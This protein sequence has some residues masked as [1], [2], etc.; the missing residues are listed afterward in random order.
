M[1]EQAQALPFP[2]APPI[3]TIQHIPWKRAFDIG[4]SLLVLTLGTPLFLLLSLF[5]AI[6]SKGPIFYKH[7]RIGRGGRSFNCYKFRTMHQGADQKLEE[8][9]NKH[10]ELHQ[11]WKANFKL[12]KD[13]RITKIG[14][15]L[16]KT[17]L[18]ELPQFFNVLKGELSIVGPRPIIQEELETHFADVAT[19]IL[20][21]RPGITGLWQVSGRS[22][23]SYRRRIL[24]D[25]TYLKRKS[26]WLD[27]WLILKTIP[28]V[29]FA[30]G[31]C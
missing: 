13:P 5:I 12:K 16:R 27:F 2:D 7:K 29:L 30:K 17:S 18:D 6:S 25:L 10:P 11:E 31:A 24:L 8:L 15:F 1:M 28:V 9:L 20:S 23:T 3:L 26:P 14:T 19:Q 4:F 22:N 21:I